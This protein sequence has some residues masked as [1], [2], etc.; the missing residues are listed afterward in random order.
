PGKP[1]PAPSTARYGAIISCGKPSFPAGTGVWVVKTLPD[2]AASLAITN[3][4]PRSTMSSRTRSRARNA[5]RPSFMWQRVGDTP[6]AGGRRGPRAQG[7]FW[8]GGVGFGGRRWGGLGGG[9]RG[10]AFRGG[11]GSAKNGGSRGTPA[12]HA[13]RAISRVLVASLPIGSVTDTETRS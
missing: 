3:E 4:T 12:R 8:G 11:F 7:V 13:S 5:E 1:R 10:G 2:A 6:S 9:R